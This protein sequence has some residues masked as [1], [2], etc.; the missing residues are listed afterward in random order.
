MSHPKHLFIAIFLVNS[1][2]TDIYL[3]NPRGSNDRLDEQGRERDNANRLFDSQNNNRGGYNV[4]Y[5]Y[6][7][8]DS[9]LTIEWTNQHSCKSSN[10]H[11]EIIIQY[12]CHDNI[13]DGSDTRTIPE[14]NQQCD[15]GDCNS[16]FRFGMNEDYAY[17]ANCKQ[18]ERN[19]GLYL[20][21]Q[22]SKN[23]IFKLEQRLVID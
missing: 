20:A 1:V 11:C 23:S 8:Q 16:D 7:L 10:A 14:S 9:V 19:K 6:Y 22:V 5:M 3:H 12:M 15:N 4:G 21:D 17:Y 18:R 13:R 2:L